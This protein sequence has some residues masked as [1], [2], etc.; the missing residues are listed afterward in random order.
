[1]VSRTK[2]LS[3]TTISG[4]LV[5]KTGDLEINT[6]PTNTNET[7][8]RESAERL[9][10]Y[11]DSYGSDPTFSLK[12]NEISVSVTGVDGQQNGLDFIDKILDVKHFTENTTV[13][14]GLLAYLVLSVAY[15]NAY[16]R[17]DSLL[18]LASI[19]HDKSLSNISADALLAYHRQELANCYHEYGA[20]NKERRVMALVM[21]NGIN[22]DQADTLERAYATMQKCN[23]KE[24]RDAELLKES[25]AQIWTEADA[26]MC[27]PSNLSAIAKYPIMAN[28]IKAVLE[29]EISGLQQ[30]LNST[31]NE[32]R[33]GMLKSERLYGAITAEAITD[34]LNEHHPEAALDVIATE[35]L[36]METKLGS[37]AYTDT[38]SKA[39]TLI[40]SADLDNITKASSMLSMLLQLE[41][42]SVKEAINEASNS[43]FPTSRLRAITERRIA[44]EM[45]AS[46]NLLTKNFPIKRASPIPAKNHALYASI[47]NTSILPLLTPKDVNQPTPG[48]IPE[49][50]PAD[51]ERAAFL[52]SV[53]YS[54]GDSEQ[55]LDRISCVLD[56]CS[57][58]QLYSTIQESYHKLAELKNGAKEIKGELSELLATLVE[59]T[60]GDPSGDKSI[61][62]LSAFLKTLDAQNDQMWQ[63]NVDNLSGVK[64]LEKDYDQ[65]E[66]GANTL[67]NK[68]S[69]HILQNIGGGSFS[70]DLLRTEAASASI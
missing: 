61:A 49:A 40:K 4:P 9:A 68:T 20:D 44:V 42:A 39:I 48:I 30:H 14:D 27:D 28:K 17:E 29:D 11:F 2:S 59:S 69:R 56:A 21:F 41:G 50:D 1:M 13:D 36:D 64:Q 67:L 65:V 66:T 7:L 26:R 54:Q 3:A 47:L 63:F 53:L 8:G 62:S 10:G 6:L 45:E 22:D 24:E 55:F 25:D 57:A 18:E 31:I 15:D 70:T 51:L 5:I 35:L 32:M 19:F 34:A 33:S 52:L 46:K 38:L 23:S 12:L 58:V 43:R 37:S 60:P 16:N